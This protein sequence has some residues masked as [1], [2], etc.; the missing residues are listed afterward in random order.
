MSDPVL[1]SCDEFIRARGVDAGREGW[2]TSLPKPPQFPFDKNKRY[3]WN[4]TTNQGPIRIRLMPEVAPMHASSTIFLARTGFYDGLRFHRVIEGF[5]A[6]GGCPLGSGT[7]GPGYTYDGEFDPKVTHSRPGLLSM[8]N[9]GPG[10]DGSQF[11]ITFVP[12]PHLDGKHSIFGE[13]TE[14]MDTVQALEGKGTRSG[15]TI[16]PLVIEKTTIEVVE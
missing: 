4:L 14:G 12:T 13:V 11:F 10:T 16:E 8:A 1:D 5:M 7:G 6:Q 9:A 2:R 15:A 3:L